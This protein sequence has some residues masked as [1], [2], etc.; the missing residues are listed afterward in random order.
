MTPIQVL[1]LGV[2]LWIILLNNIWSMPINKAITKELSNIS[3]CYLAEPAIIVDLTLSIFNVRLLHPQPEKK[4]ILIL[5]RMIYIVRLGPT[6]PFQASQKGFFL[7]SQK[8][9][10]QLTPK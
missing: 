10:V 5:R 6:C 1:I 7:G 3:S 2:K 9:L 8:I 4:S